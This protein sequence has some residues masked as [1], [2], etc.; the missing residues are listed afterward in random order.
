MD[1]GRK[2]KK[3]SNAGRCFKQINL[4]ETIKLLKNYE[5]QI[6]EI[7]IL[8]FFSVTFLFLSDLSNRNKK[9]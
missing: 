9:L 3:R 1:Y 8:L 6:H 2:I 7:E 4:S 5:Q